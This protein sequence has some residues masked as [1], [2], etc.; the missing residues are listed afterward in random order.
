LFKKGLAMEKVIKANILARATS[1]Q[2]GMKDVLLGE[3]A[4]YTS[5]GIYLQQHEA[6]EGSTT[7]TDVLI[8]VVQGAGELSYHHDGKDITVYIETSDLLIIPAHTVFTFLNTFQER[9]VL[10]Y[11][12]QHN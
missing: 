12:A 5:T 8:V 10:L 3:S 6:Y 4:N 2:Q 1:L 7:R 11:A 9:C